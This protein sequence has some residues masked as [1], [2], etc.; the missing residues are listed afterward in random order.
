MN[1]TPFLAGLALAALPSGVLAQQVAPP[2]SLF[3]PVPVSQITRF[4]EDAAAIRQDNV[5]L[6]EELILGEL[7]G[8]AAAEEVTLNLFPDV[9][10][11]G[12]LMDTETAYAGGYVVRYD[13]GN[14]GWDYAALSVLGDA[15]SG[16]VHVGE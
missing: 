6:N 16:V 10:F 12:R 13:L 15:V 14:D 8:R 11:T 7:V 1:A 5:T 9:S 4:H 3:E 2:P